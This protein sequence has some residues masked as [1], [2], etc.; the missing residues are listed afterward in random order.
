MVVMEKRGEPLE[1]GGYYTL[2]AD[3][4]WTTIIVP[5]PLAPCQTLSHSL[6]DLVLQKMGVTSAV[7]SLNNNNP[8]ELEAVPDEFPEVEDDDFSYVQPLEDT[9]GFHWLPPQLPRKDLF[10]ARGLFVDRAGQ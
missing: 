5:G 2:P 9:E 10:K 8:L 6:T 1:V 7:D 4:T 3:L